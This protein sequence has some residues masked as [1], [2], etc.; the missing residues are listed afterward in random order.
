LSNQKAQTA[1]E[2][3]AMQTRNLLKMVSKAEVELRTKMRG[4]SNPT[5]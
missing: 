3:D 5:E 4:M 2:Y 1:A